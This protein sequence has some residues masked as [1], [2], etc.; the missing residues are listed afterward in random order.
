MSGPKALSAHLD[1]KPG[2]ENE[3]ARFLEAGRDLLEQ[4]VC[5]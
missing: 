4:R 3:L 1:A 2:K 5:S